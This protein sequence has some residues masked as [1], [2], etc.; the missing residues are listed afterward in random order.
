MKIDKAALNLAS[1]NGHI[2]IVKMLLKQEGIDVNPENV[3]FN[4]FIFKNYVC[5]WLKLFDSA[6]I[7]AA[8]NG[9]IELAKLLLEQDGIDINS[10]NIC[11]FYSR[12]ILII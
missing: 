4:N 6:L 5:N 7:C 8:L 3:C 11:L 10:E 9:D 2:E 1:S 12:F